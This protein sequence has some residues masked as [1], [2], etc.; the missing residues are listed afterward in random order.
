MSF[1]TPGFGVDPDAEWGTLQILE[2]TPRRIPTEN[3]DYREYYANVRDA[4]LGKASLA[5]TAE[6]AWRTTRL[7][8][9][10]RESSKE[11]RTLAVDLSDQP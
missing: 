1:T 6:Q 11:Q 9:L 7:V 5:V 3:G 8:E 10:A 4:L 2:E